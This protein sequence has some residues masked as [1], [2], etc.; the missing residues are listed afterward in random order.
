MTKKLTSKD[1]KRLA[2]DALHG[3]WRTAILSGFV[4]SLLGSTVIQNTSNFN[5]EYSEQISEQD[6]E[7]LLEFPI[8]D[9]FLSYL[10]FFVIISI[11]FGLCV[12]VISG[13][14]RLGYAS[15]NLNLID[16]KDALFSDLFSHTDRKWS[17]FCMNFF[18]GLYVALW[19]LLLVIPGIVK[20]L[21]YSMTPYILAE[22]PEMTANEA[23]AESEFIMTGHKWRLFKMELSFMGWALLSALPPAAVLM[24][25]ILTEAPI[26]ALILAVLAAIPLSAGNLFLRPYTEAAFAAFYRSLIPAKTESIVEETSYVL[27]D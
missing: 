13:A 16:G 11:I 23:I 8:V 21:A 6:L 17:G 14:V 7:R 1:Y 10:P 26:E 12:L 18:M 27:E 2:L 22:H 19:S 4:A 3:H 24:P 20:V 9:A 15:Y 5:F 25:A